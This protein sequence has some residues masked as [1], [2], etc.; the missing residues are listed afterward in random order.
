MQ[1][2]QASAVLEEALLLTSKSFE[3]AAEKKKQKQTQ[4]QKQK[5]N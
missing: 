2:M 1:R 5:Q 4:M 3:E